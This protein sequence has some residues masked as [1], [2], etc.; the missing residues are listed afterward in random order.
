MAHQYTIENNQASFTATTLARFSK[1]FTA[2][3]VASIGK[4]LT[5]VAT[6]NIKTDY[7]AHGDTQRTSGVVTSSTS[8][9]SVTVP[10]GIFVVGDIGKKVAIGVPFYPFAGIYDTIAGVPDSTHVTLTSNAGA[11]FSGTVQ[12][13]EWGTDDSAAFMAWNADFQGQRGVVLQIPDGRY[14]NTTGSGIGPFFGIKGLQVTGIGGSPNYILSDM[15]NASGGWFLGGCVT[16]QYQDNAH[17]ARTASVS[18]GASTIQFLTPSDTSKM[19]LG[20]WGLM[21][22]DD[23]QDD[24]QAPTNQY[25]YEYCRIIGIDAVAG[26][27]TILNPLV[28]SYKSTWPYYG[29]HGGP[30]NGGPA[31]LYA[32]EPGWDC[33]HE[34]DDLNLDQY[35]QTNG[36]GR[37]IAFVRGSSTGFGIYPSR[38]VNWSATNF[39]QNNAGKESEIDKVSGTVTISGGTWGGIKT[40]SPSPDTF[41]ISGSATVANLNGTPKNMVVNNST[42]TAARFGPVAFGYTSSVVA[43]S[44]SFGSIT[45]IGGVKE[46]DVFGVGAWTLSGGIFKRL[47]TGGTGAPPQW[48]T[49]GGYCFLGGSYDWSAIFQVTDIYEDGTYVYVKTTLNGLPNIPNAGVY[50]IATHP[51]PALTFTGCTGCDDAL[52]WSQVPAGAPL[53]SNWK[54]NYPGNISTTKPLIRM[55]GKLT[56]ARF[57]VSVGYSAGTFT[58]DGPS[59]FQLSNATLL[60]WAPSIDL[61][62]PGVRTVTAAGAPALL[63]SDSGLDLPGDRKIWLISNQ[64]TPKMFGAVGA[65]SITLELIT[66]Q[67]I[68]YSSVASVNQ[69]Q[70]GFFRHVVQ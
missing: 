57:T 12:Q 6:R 55:A 53:G 69:S 7:G 3:Q 30:D 11:A 23:V 40:Q 15:L 20:G 54:L 24:N 47:K 39:T 46:S 29:Y 21:T 14:I 63:G 34:Y 10:N 19:T 61:T 50:S 31:T 42:I 13:I 56:L 18:A 8:S 17:H 2:A 16:G 27:I 45:E 66:D 62:T 33:D 35:L 38:N 48:G 1:E 70:R 49:P 9:T 28:N 36:I 59:V 5:Q 37:S 43:T 52:S 68:V 22:G 4:L 41:T 25:L 67:G 44:S 65:G 51:C 64:I 58:L 60:I 26:V 32:L